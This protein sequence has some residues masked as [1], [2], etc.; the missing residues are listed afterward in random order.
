[1]DKGRLEVVCGPMFSGKTEI[2]L[3]HIRRALIAKQVVQVFKPEIDTRAGTHKI[4]SH[5]NL[6]IA[7]HPVPAD[8][9][10]HLWQC[11]E[12]QTGVVAIDEAQFFNSSIVGVCERLV[13]EG[14]R[15][16]VA[17]LDLDY[18]GAPFGSMPAILYIADQVDKLTAI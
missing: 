6:E 11:V 9:A 15:V 13:D 1:M 14:K 7:A 10:T 4:A 18:R 8:N 12:P 2:L 5:S 17:G 3:H 16:I